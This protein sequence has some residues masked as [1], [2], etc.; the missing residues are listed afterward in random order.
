[1][2]PR[3]ATAITATPPTMAPTMIPVGK[4]LPPEGEDGD[5]EELEV[6]ELEEPINVPGVFSGV[7]RKCRCEADKENT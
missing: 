6:V 5:W 4:L 3:T 7:S 1:M 2:I